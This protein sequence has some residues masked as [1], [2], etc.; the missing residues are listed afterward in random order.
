M[1]HRLHG[2]IQNDQFTALLDGSASSSAS[3]GSQAKPDKEIPGA[4]VRFKHIANSKPLLLKLFEAIDAKRF[5]KAPGEFAPE[6]L[7]G[8]MAGVFCVAMRVVWEDELPR[9]FCEE[10]KCE[11]VFISALSQRY[12]KLGKTLGVRPAVDIQK[13][14]HYVK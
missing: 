14:F 8:N 2:L 9:K 13:A 12:S 11:D 3:A 7:Q 1:L 4:I 6:W 10:L 5:F